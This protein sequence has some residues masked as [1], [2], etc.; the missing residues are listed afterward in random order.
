MKGVAVAA[1]PAAKKCLRWC[2]ERPGHDGG[3][4]REIDSKLVSRQNGDT[5]RLSIRI[6]MDHHDRQVTEVQLDD[7]LVHLDA[8][9]HAWL[10]N[11]LR[12]SKKHT[13]D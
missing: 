2:D 4:S 8:K 12:D 13:K 11:R 6:R 5:V 7:V 9:D 1:T 10:L 3:C